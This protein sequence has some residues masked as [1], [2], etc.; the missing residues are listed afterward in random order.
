MLG[1][2]LR[3][4]GCINRGTFALICTNAKVDASRLFAVGSLSAFISLRGRVHNARCFTIV[5]IRSYNKF[6]F[7]DCRGIGTIIVR[8]TSD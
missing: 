2:E 3:L 4:Y 5:P 1:R 6:R 7:R 8:L